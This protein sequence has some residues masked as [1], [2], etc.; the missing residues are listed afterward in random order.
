M[1]YYK[2]CLKNEGKEIVDQKR[3]WDIVVFNLRGKNWKMVWYCKENEALIRQ[4]FT[5][6]KTVPR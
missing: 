4:K 3:G 1:L 2:F 5:K 6:L